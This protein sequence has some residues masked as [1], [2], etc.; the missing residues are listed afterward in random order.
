M[1]RAILRGK[2]EENFCTRA[3][4]C[5]GASNEE[6][7]QKPQAETPSTMGHYTIARAAA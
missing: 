4:T 3:A 2:I 5:D 7:D 1:K 6:H